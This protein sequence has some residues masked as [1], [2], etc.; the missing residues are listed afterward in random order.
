M[1]KT[2]IKFKRF[3]TEDLPLSAKRFVASP[4]TECTGADNKDEGS[5]ARAELPIALPPSPQNQSERM[6][7]HQNGELMLQHNEC[8]TDIESTDGKQLCGTEVSNLDGECPDGNFFKFDSHNNEGRDEAESCG[9]ITPNTQILG[10]LMEEINRR[11]VEEKNARSDGGDS[12]KSHRPRNDERTISNYRK[13]TQSMNS[14]DSEYGLL[15]N[16]EESGES[17]LHLF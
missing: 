6:V 17:N 3:E 9:R 13:L 7:E 5:S 14:S 11:L 15:M 16:S 10:S 8:P 2:P 12:P 1:Q 4:V